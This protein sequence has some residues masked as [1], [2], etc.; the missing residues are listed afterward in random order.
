MCIGV[1]ALVCM[2]W[3]VPT[4]RV[5]LWASGCCISRCQQ[6]GEAK[7]LVAGLTECLRSAAG[8]TCIGYIY[9]LRRG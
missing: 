9:F 4:K 7:D 8:R 6:Q 2:R 5:E 3:S 1:C